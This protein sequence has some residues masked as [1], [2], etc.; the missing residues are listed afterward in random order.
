MSAISKPT[1]PKLRVPRDPG[2]LAYIWISSCLKYAPSVLP[3]GILFASVWGFGTY[4][5][6]QDQWRH[7]S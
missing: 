1:A 6:N 7:Q 3:G 2:Y 5:A 4:D